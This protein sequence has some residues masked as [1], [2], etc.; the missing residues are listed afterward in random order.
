MT[1]PNGF[2]QINWILS[3]SSLPTGAQVTMGVDVSGNPGTPEDLANFAI[4]QWDTYFAPSIVDGYVLT[5]CLVKFGPD[6]TGPSALVG[7][8]VNGEAPGDPAP[9]NLAYLVRKNTAF[10]G[11]AGRGRMYIPGVPEEQVTGAGVLDGTWRANL[12]ASLELSRADFDGVAYPWVLL[13]QPGSPISSPTPITSVSVQSVCA[14]Q[15]QRL[16]R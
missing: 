1:I 3:G 13:H 7:T 8:T 11:R 15:R 16:R 10:G 12:E 4:N 6:A 9:P 5:A 2:A 14:T